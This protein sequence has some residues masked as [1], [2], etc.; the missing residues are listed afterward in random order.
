MMSYTVLQ[1]QHV[2]SPS[3][4]ISCSRISQTVTPE[5]HQSAS[6]RTPSRTSDRLRI[7][8]RVPGREQSGRHRHQYH[9]SRSCCL[10]IYLVVCT[11]TYLSKHIPSCLY[12]CLVVYTYTFLPMHIPSCLYIYLVVCTYT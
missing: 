4:G 8:R 2:P 1:H 11:Y 3:E 12:I 9:H 10:Y 5:N 6:H 7:E